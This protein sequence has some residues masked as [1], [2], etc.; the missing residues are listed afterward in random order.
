[1]DDDHRFK[2]LVPCRRHIEDSSFKQG[3]HFLPVLRINGGYRNE[4]RFPLFIIFQVCQCVLKVLLVCIY[5]FQQQNFVILFN[6]FKNRVFFDIVF[7][8]FYFLF[9]SFSVFWKVT[10]A[11]NQSFFGSFLFKT[12][13]PAFRK[14]KKGLFWY[15]RK[16]LYHFR[17]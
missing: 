17:I 2:I 16:I 3:I 11:E 13:I 14:E 15:Q 9:F 8:L 1:M 12:Y 5:H 10:V 7:K 6:L 4:F